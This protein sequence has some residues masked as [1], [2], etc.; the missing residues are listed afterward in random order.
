MLLLLL[1]LASSAR[2]IIDYRTFNNITLYEI[3]V[4]C[5]QDGD[6]STGFDQGI[7]ACHFHGD[8]PGITQSINYIKGLGVNAIWLTP[9]F[10]SRGDGKEDSTGYHP[11]DF[12]NVDPH[13]G[14][15]AQ[16]KELV[17]TFHAEEIYVILD[18]TFGHHKSGFIAVSPNGHYPSGPSEPVSYPGSL[19]FFKDVIRFWI[20]TYGIDGWRLSDASELT[21]A[22]QDRN[23][24]GELRVAAE[25]A[26]LE[27]MEKGEQ[28]GTLCYLVADIPADRKTVSSLAYDSGCG[29][30]VVSFFDAPG[31]DTLVRTYACDENGT[32]EHVARNLRTLHFRTGDADG[33]PAGTYPNLYLTTHTR[34]RFGNLVRREFDLQNYDDQYWTLYR[35]ALAAM[36]TVSGPITIYYGDEIGDR[37][38]CFYKD[39]DCPQQVT[40]TEMARSNGQTSAFSARQKDLYDY[41]S[42]L[43]AVRRGSDA[44]WRGEVT[45]LVATDDVYSVMKQYGDAKPLYIVYTVGTDKVSDVL[46]ESVD[47]TFTELITGTEVQITAGKYETAAWQVYIFEPN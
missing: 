7:G 22:A 31:R 19:E 17:D 37:V 1:G 16:F 25:E 10:N 40:G 9:V 15:N 5:F 18:G 14:T 28:W 3:Y 12:F 45:E 35:A 21:R 8:L 39:G 24:L 36:T 4:A 13:F 27:R 44:L 2:A 11:S 32:A 6:P 43:L 23:Y 38:E 30:G 46:P 42:H 20:E 33:F 29:Q 34:W 47:G 26:C 41:T